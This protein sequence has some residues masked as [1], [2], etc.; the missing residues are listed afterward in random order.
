MESATSTNNSLPRLLV[1]ADWEV[2][3]HGVALACVR[4]CNQQER[5]IALLVPAWLHGADWVGDPYASVP[6][7]SRALSALAAHCDSAGLRVHSAEVGDPDPGAAITDALLTQPIDELMICVGKRWFRSRRFGLAHR[8]ARSS[9]LPVE[10]V[11][12]ARPDAKSH[13]HAWSLLGRGHCLA[14]EARVA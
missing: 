12:I 1:V 4:R 5:S 3:P 13:R 10:Q 6:C 8:I 11:T 9:G 14:S 7:A 2:D